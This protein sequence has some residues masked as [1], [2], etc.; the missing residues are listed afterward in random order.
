[1]P[2]APSF[3]DLIAQ[4][5]AEA[6]AQRGSLAFNDGDI[7][8]AQAHGAGAMGD[9]AIRF[10]V[11]AFKET[12]IDGAKAA[13]LTALVD[14]RLNL[15]RQPATSSQVLLTFTRTSAGAGE[16]LAAGFVVGTAFDS[17]GNTVLFTLD[18]NVTFPNASN[19]PI[20]GNATAQVAGRD[21]NVAAA[22]VTRLVDTTTDP[23]IVV[24]NVALAAGGND[25][26]SDPELRV[27]ARTFWLVLRRGTLAA[28]EFG[29]LQVP[30]VRIAK[31]T[32]SAITGIV[33][34]VVTDSDGGSTA[35][36]VADAEAEIEIWRAAGSI[37]TTVGGTALIV[38]VT[39]TLIVNDGVDAAVLAPLCSDAIEARMRKQ[40]QGEVLYLDSIKAAAV[41]VDPDAID[42]LVLTLPAANVTP[43][44]FQVIRPGVITLS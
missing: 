14:D 42:G 7:T 11:Q 36:M 16:T 24:T 5:E 12:F 2:V 10:T 34:L 13:A 28:L 15:Q 33:T 43:T 37:V 6:L 22:T 17:A 8:E 31:A 39:G 29:A 4:F 21:G 32:E 3:D 41:N 19:G 30:S 1:M 18:A 44:V 35:Q 23:T 20:T 9:A 38:A 26:E 25:E 27:R 40:R